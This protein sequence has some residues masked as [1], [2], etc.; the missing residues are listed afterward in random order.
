MLFMNRDGNAACKAIVHTHMPG[1]ALMSP[2]RPSGSCLA[3]VAW[4]IYLNARCQS[5]CGEASDDEPD[6]EER[7]DHQRDAMSAI[8]RVEGVF[9]PNKKK[10]SQIAVGFM[11]QKCG[12]CRRRHTRPPQDGV[13]TSEPSS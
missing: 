13:F 1:W 7:L 9:V 5:G 3:V 6:S 2:V 11:S 8:V 10:P 12:W 4:L